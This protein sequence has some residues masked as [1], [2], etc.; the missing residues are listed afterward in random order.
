MI[1]LPEIGASKLS[2]RFIFCRADAL[3]DKCR[4]MKKGISRIRDGNRGE[5]RE[6][7]ERVK[8]GEQIDVNQIRDVDKRGLP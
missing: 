2:G 4:R 7:E 3:E 6:N 5:G 1:K 8:R